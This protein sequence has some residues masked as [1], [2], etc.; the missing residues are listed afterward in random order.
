MQEDS[1]YVY[2]LKDPRDKR[3]KPFYIGKGTGTRAWEHLTNIDDTSV[4][5]RLKVGRWGV[6]NNKNCWDQKICKKYLCKSD[7]TILLYKFPVRSIY[8]FKII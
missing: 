8:S 5:S 6:K 4:T 1:Y 7:E 2:A 3:A